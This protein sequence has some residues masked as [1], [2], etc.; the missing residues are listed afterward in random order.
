MAFSTTVGAGVWT[1]V[2]PDG[3]AI[4]AVIGLNDFGTAIVSS[5]ASGAGT[6]IDTYQVQTG[7]FAVLPWP[8]PPSVLANP[9]GF[10]HQQ[11]RPVARVSEA[12]LIPDDPEAPVVGFTRGVFATP[13]PT[14][15]GRARRGQERSPPAPGPGRSCNGHGTARDGAR[16]LSGG[17]SGTA[18]QVGDG[19]G[20]V[21]VGGDKE[22]PCWCQ[23]CVAAESTGR[24]RGRGILLPEVVFPDMVL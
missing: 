7:T 3:A 11:Q 21:S 12:Q 22:H 6:Q 8:L 9:S 4:S 10:A 14:S 24:G 18:R 2:E 1:A 5:Q 23:L 19:M 17:W 13:L 20:R 15:T 16:G